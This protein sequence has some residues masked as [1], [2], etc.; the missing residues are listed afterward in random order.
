ML[1]LYS[2][3]PFS[4]RLLQSVDITYR[5]NISTIRAVGFTL[6]LRLL[7]LSLTEY[8]R[9]LLAL[10]IQPAISY[11]A[12][13]SLHVYLLSLTVMV[14]ASLLP[15]LGHF[16]TPRTCYHIHDVNPY[17]IIC[18]A[19]VKKKIRGPNI[20]PLRHRK[21]IVC[22]YNNNNIILFIVNSFY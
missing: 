16:L 19:Y 20:N 4:F 9:S 15:F 2:L 22:S 11:I 13:F 1:K 17:N 8:L 3:E 5:K 18:F 7:T 6:Y 10:S 14:V 12:R 21:Y